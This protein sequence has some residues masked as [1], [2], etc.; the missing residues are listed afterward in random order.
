MDGIRVSPLHGAGSLQHWPS[1]DR[2]RELVVRLMA[3]GVVVRDE[4][5]TEQAL[6]DDSRRVE[7]LLSDYFSVAGPYRHHDPT[8][9][10]EMGWL[11]GLF[12]DTF[13]LL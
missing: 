6:Y 7:K 8:S 4:D 1:M 3:Y 13:N 12:A 10:A 2:F 9:P 5:G 11:A